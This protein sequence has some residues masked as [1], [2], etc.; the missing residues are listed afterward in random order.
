MLLSKYGITGLTDIPVK[1][2]IKGDTQRTD[3]L[4]VDE[5]MIRN[6]SNLISE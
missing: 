5:E 2:Y 6:I 3:K 1:E 4:P